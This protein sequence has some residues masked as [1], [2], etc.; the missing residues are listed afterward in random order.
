MGSLPLYSI[1]I[2]PAQGNTH[3]HTVVFLH[4]R[5]D[6]AANFCNSLQYLHDSQGHTLTDT[7]PSVQWVFPQAPKRRCA[8]QPN[9]E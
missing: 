6:H 2:P 9:E 5:G 4:G 8:S 1:Q 7:F 3:S